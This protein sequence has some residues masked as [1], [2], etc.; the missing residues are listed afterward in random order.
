MQK[1]LICFYT[2]CI[3]IYSTINLQCGEENIEHCTK[4]G[5]GDNINSCEKCEEKYFPIMSNVICLPCNDPLYGN[6][7]CGGKC[8]IAG[9]NYL[10]SRNILC[11]NGGCIEGYYEIDE[12]FCIPCSEGSPNC[13]KCT[14]GPITGATDSDGNEDNSNK[15]ICKECIN[16][17]YKLNSDGV[18][19]KRKS[20]I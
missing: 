7:G 12:G 19:F 17:Q 1:T 16:N 18:C 4:C 8:T 3:L 5:T 9:N 14:Y 10:E 6:Y 11:E 20:G 13:I 15:F 2:L